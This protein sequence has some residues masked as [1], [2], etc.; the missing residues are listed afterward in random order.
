[1]ADENLQYT[2]FRHKSTSRNNALLHFLHPL[3]DTPKCVY[4]LT[5]GK[6]SSV[7]FNQYHLTP[8][9]PR[10]L[11]QEEAQELLNLEQQ[12][13][14]KQLEIVTLQPFPRPRLTSSCSVAQSLRDR[15][16]EEGMH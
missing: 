9:S 7:P 13:Y 15:L 11:T 3:R 8:I 16:M 6:D 12:F 4:D 5:L 14:K 1:M 2:I 10:D